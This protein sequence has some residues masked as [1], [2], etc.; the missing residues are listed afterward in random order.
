MKVSTTKMTEL[1]GVTTKEK[2]VNKKDKTAGA[3][4]SKKKATKNKAKKKKQSQHSNVSRLQPLMP[5]MPVKSAHTS[6]TPEMMAKILLILFTHAKGTYHILLPEFKIFTGM[7]N[8]ISD[9]YLSDIDRCLRPN[10]FCLLRMNNCFVVTTLG[11]MYT[12]RHIS[13]T[14]LNSYL[15]S[16]NDAKI[17]KIYTKFNNNWHWSLK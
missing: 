12:T 2:V 8:E 3:L 9:E 10:N 14:I 15:H 16:C 11:E 5:D 13:P 17:E 1:S 6:R 4:S 7:S